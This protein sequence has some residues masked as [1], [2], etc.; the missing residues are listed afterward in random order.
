MVNEECRGC[1][2]SYTEHDVMRG[3]GGDDVVTD[4]WQCCSAPQNDDEYTLWW[5][6]CPLKEKV[7]SD[8]GGRRWQR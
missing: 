2:Y 4:G 7:A 1:K 6:N 3:Y 8:D 5:S